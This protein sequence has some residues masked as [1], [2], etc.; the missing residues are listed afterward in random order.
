L[1]RHWRYQETFHGMDRSSIGHFQRI[2][3]KVNYKRFWHL[4]YAIRA[5]KASDRDSSDPSLMTA[6]LTLD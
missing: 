3:A 5:Q 2:F 1:H 6:K 4:V